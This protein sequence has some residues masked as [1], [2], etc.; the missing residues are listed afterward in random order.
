MRKIKINLGEDNCE[1]QKNT[2]MAAAMGTI[3]AAAG[4]A[5]AQSTHST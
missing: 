4:P 5:S 1:N 3:L 2:L